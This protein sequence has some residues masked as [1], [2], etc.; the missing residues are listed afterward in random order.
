MKK[1]LSKA[2]ALF[3]ALV[4][5]L[6][7]FPVLGFATE[8]GES[9][10]VVN[11]LPEDQSYG[12]LF[13][14]DG[15]VVGAD[16]S[17]GSAPA[18]A[19]TLNASGDKINALPNGAA[20][21]KF[22]KLSDSDYYLTL[23]GKYLTIKDLDDQNMEQLILSDTA[24]SGAKWTFEADR[25]EAGWYNLK[26]AEYTYNGKAVY[27]EV[28]RG[29]VKPWG[30]NTNSASAFRFKVFS[31]TADED[32]RVGE[33]MDAGSLPV[34][35]Q[36]Y[37]I[38]NHN[39]RAVFGQ[40]TG[41]DVAAPALLAAPATLNSDGGLNYYDVADG[42]MIFTVHKSGTEKNPIFNFENNGKYLAMPEN[43][44]DENGKVNNDETLLMI[45][46][47]EDEEKQG[48]AC[49][50][51][52]ER[53]GGYEI[54]NKAAKYGNYYCS[55]EFFNDV[56]SG[57]T[58]KADSVELFAMNFIPMEDKDGVGYVVNPT[59][60]LKDPDPA[61]GSDCPVE[62]E[63]HDVSDP[64]EIFAQYMVTDQNDTAQTP[65]QVEPELVG[66]K[67]SFTIPAADLEN[68]KAVAIEIGITDALGKT[69]HVIKTFPVR[70]EPLILTA[71][72]AANSATG[73]E[74]RPEI[75]V[76]FANVKQNPSFQ[77]LLNGEAVTGAVEGDKYSY[78]PTADLADGKQTVSVTITRADG[79]SVNKSWNFFIGEGGETLYFGQIHA[80]TAEY[81]DGVGTLEDAYE[82]AQGVD[83]LDFII[84]TDHSNYFDTTSTATTSSYY[85]LSSLLKNSAGSTTKWE[86]A[87]AT[88]KEYNELY[89]DFLCVYGYEMTWSG[90]PGHTN[91]FN[92][93]GVV[94]RNNA[95]L[96]NKTGYAGMH[97][98][99]DLMVNAEHGLDNKGE[100]AKTTRG[101]AEV[102]GVNATK[103]IPFDEAGNSV[104]VV[105][106]F[107][108]PGKTFGNFDNYAGY[109]AQR[110]DVLNLIEVGNGEGKVGGSAYFPSY[111]EYDLCLSMGW[112]V[113]P[114]N[115]QDNHKGNW[116][117][118]NTCRDVIL[119]DDFSEIGLYR[120]LDAR[121]VYSTEDQNLQIHYELTANG[122]TYKLGDIAP[123]EE[124][125]Q[126]ETVTVKVNVSDPDRADKIATVE[127][128]GEGGKSV[129]KIEV[130]A[131]DFEQ[132]IE[133][134]N[135]E[136]FYYI[137]VVEA[138]K[139]I[140]VTAPVWVKEAVPVA[141]DLETS[142]A[143]AAQG[144]EET[145]TAK[146]TNGSE[147]EP[148][149]LTG[150][151][152]EAE[153][154]VLEERTGLTETVAAGTVKTVAV[155]FTPSA[156]DPAAVKT[157]EITVTFNVIFKGKELVYV[158]TISETSYPP[159]MMTYI[160]LDKGHD[161]FYVSGDY[162]G[163][164]GNFI[165]ICAQRGILCK[166]IDKG[167]MTKEN[168]AR[169]KAVL[170]TVP[171]VKGD[172]LP[173]VWT[174]EE[175]EALADY[176]ANGGTILSFS[177]SD[178]YDPDD[179]ADA[180]YENYYSSANL[181]NMVNEAIGA[182]TRF[183]RG[184]V[185][186]NDKKANEAYRVYFDGRELVGDHL[187]TEGIVPS[188][189]GR[190]Q[191]YNGTG[192]TWDPCARFTDV[193]R[194]SWYH[195][196]V[197][198]VLE[199]GL[200]SGTGA[201]KFGPNA[202]LTREMFV[203]I[204]WQVAGKPAPTIE[205]PFNDV[206][207]G[208]YS[209][210]AILW[211]F[212]NGIT[213]GKA[214]GKFDRKGNVTRQ[215]LASFLYKYAELQGMDISAQADLSGFPDAGTASGWA[216]KPLSWAV[217]NGLISGNK[218]DGVAMLQPK[219]T[220][221]RGQVAVILKKFVQNAEIEL[222]KADTAVTTLIAPYPTTWV[223][224]Y[225]ANFDGSSYVPDYEKDLVMAEM[226]SD[227][228]L[229]TAEK[230]SGG[231]WLVCSG[232]TFISNYDL[233][234]GD[235]ANQQYE[236]Y[237]LV[238][239]IL[240]FIKDGEFDGEIT[241]I[242][243]VHKGEVGQ[244]FTIEGWVTS[245]ASDYDKDTAFF[246]CIYIQDETRGINAFPVSGYYSI[247]MKV[248][249]H[250]GVTYYCGEIELNLSTDYNG[251]IK[252]ISNDLTVIEPKAVTC[253]E[254]MSD[255]NIGILMKITGKITD[256]HETAGVVDMIYVDDGSGEEAMLFINGYI[257]K[258]SHALDGIAVGMNIE[259]VGIGSR[260]VDEASGGAD[261]QI[262]DDIDPSLFIKRLRV[263]SRDEIE[264]WADEL[265]TTE[266]EAAVAE[267]EA[268]DRSLYT[269]SS[270]A[271]LDEALAAAQA[272]MA[273]PN[274]DQ[275]M[276]TEALNALRTALDGL[277]EIPTNGFAAATALAANDRVIIYFPDKSLALADTLNGNKV[278]E[279]S[280]TPVEGMLEPATGVAVYTVEYPEG[281]STN[282]YLK[283]ANG[284]Y[285]TTGA[286]GNSM[287]F[288][289]S[290][291][292][293]SLWYL[294]VKDA[295]AKTVFVRST[296]A[297]YQEGNKNQALEY[298]N[299]FTTYGWKDNVNYVFQLYVQPAE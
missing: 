67:G 256:F 244:E 257:Q 203:T 151:K 168:L 24:E 115:N 277:E 227:F 201:D 255:D 141:A 84:I 194:T 178:R 8:E 2:L 102:T 61:I 179:P 88:A 269:E 173:S 7:V 208:N 100:E 29:A 50:T 87:R 221:T 150:Y 295:D 105:S 18:K 174:A 219:G 149:T 212:E 250:G 199:H 120:A 215:E 40:P 206:K 191:W 292:E 112:H 197:D 225:K 148:L 11:G 265:D 69:M 127:I 262:G 49:W 154:R 74:K 55:I 114:T 65:K 128:I 235:P 205:N 77:M 270:L 245:N 239:N 291:N 279:V 186:D 86:E 136:G 34:D 106:Q 42:G 198:F 85:D 95:E 17:D 247:G 254:A 289:D 138:D 26:N 184:I 166:Y 278:G 13:N 274:K 10:D 28:Y 116:G 240:D 260:D 143:V 249:A 6:S 103:Y 232:A 162:A 259:G 222:P 47:P 96:N 233:K 37:V 160:G 97:R 89:D 284:K 66:R 113:A 101:G 130:D 32:G 145:V 153:G 16:V 108:H 117:D 110:D 80:H 241:P 75:G 45:D 23:G 200:M 58:F 231:G 82:H 185:V 73:E 22:L 280:V 59:L 137:R 39:A 3:L 190:Y 266:L 234:Y 92:T 14:I 207:P 293:Y 125:D 111:E 187:F 229:A 31:T 122:E 71:F 91:S 237:L 93:Y 52:V 193:K 70:D 98:Y 263:R 288:E 298:Y 261:G 181:S 44:V 21:F 129:K 290:P 167:E 107:N 294:Q 183:V 62:F 213:S 287:S 140:A 258:E 78:T 142:V 218:V 180:P 282:F 211:A 230:L 104:P 51:L 248:R 161:N 236:N 123:I 119:T 275:R 36:T 156:T 79:K 118:S 209:Y 60:E 57:W 224:N 54:K 131:N 283:M 202:K 4:M 9:A 169:F 286:T 246:D 109:T 192:I 12:V 189:N 272:V 33:I 19:A 63:I 15:Y 216:K 132:E 296:N 172:G 226:G 147:S 83:D 195:S 297:A 177:K 56:F 164:E 155:P 20:V 268:I 267:A 299:G 1:H 99:N 27:L 121:R 252:V 220:A 176:A 46:W 159:E 43:T 94:S 90:G 76:T 35:G 72:P 170:I 163:N 64:V 175:L 238:C 53:A 253:A 158:K 133:I 81:S 165:D 152:V 196:A 273:D 126:P 134:P 214:E 157:Y 243:D 271:A 68:G 285:L 41:E 139:D 171:R 217:A 182:Q 242:A 48:Y 38:Y 135:T 264:I 124:E 223:A 188:S 204:L 5:V 276:V 144:E 251:S 228:A 25:T 30:Y 146:L 281:D 210:K